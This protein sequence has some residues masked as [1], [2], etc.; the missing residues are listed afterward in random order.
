MMRMSMMEKAL[1]V[2]M[3]A[4]AMLFSE[5]K[6]AYYCKYCG[7]KF[8]SASSTRIGY[9]Q[10]SSNRNHIAITCKNN[11]FICENCGETFSNASSVRIGYCMYGPNKKHELP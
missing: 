2:M 10:Y 11:K 6:A 8:T 1:F 4:T 7:E 3:L 5:E 9:C